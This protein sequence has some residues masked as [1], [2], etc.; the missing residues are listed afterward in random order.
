MRYSI[1]GFNQEQLLKLQKEQDGKIK[2]LDVTD[3]LILRNIADFMNRGKVVK[4]T[5]DDKV[6]FSIQYSVILED[7]PIL[8]I[9]KQA[10]SDRLDKMVFLDVLEKIVVKNQCG[11]FV[12]FRMGKEYEN[13]LFSCKSSETTPTSSEI[14]VQECSTTNHNTNI[15]NNTI[16]DKEERDKSLSKKEQKDELFEQCWKDYRRKGSKAKAKAIWNKLTQDEKDRVQPHIKAYV[17]SR[18]VQYQKDFDGY[19]KNKLF[20][21][22]VFSN[23]RV[24]YDPT[25]FDDN[26]YRPTLNS[27]LLFYNEL[28]C[29]LYIGYFNGFIGDGYEDSNRPNGAT[30]MLNN[31]RGTITWNKEQKKWILTK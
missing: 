1:L 27:Q 30:I 22:I 29:Y 11:T 26:E 21:T 14:Q 25:L 16:I 2:K 7:L 17:S 18:E 19:L 24:L 13:L 20:L 3:I 8:D 23:N 12:A 31:G 5:I 9:K 6:Y 15:T 10:L 28:N 4:Y